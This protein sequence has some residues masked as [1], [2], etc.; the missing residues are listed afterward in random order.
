[1]LR[2][3][4]VAVYALALLVRLENLRGV[5]TQAGVFPIA[6][7]SYHHLRFICAG[8]ASLP[9]IPPSD[10]W[11]AFPEGG[12]VS[13]PFGADLVYALAAA[14]FGGA[15]DV[16]RC[17]EVAAWFTPIVSALTAVLVAA[18]AGRLRGPMAAFV[19]GGTAAL[20]PALTITGGVGYVD[21]HLF[22]S[23]TVAL[24]L[25]LWL[26]VSA[27][28]DNDRATVARAAAAGV[29]IAFGVLSTTV[30]ALLVPIAAVV[31][32][33]QLAGAWR[34]AAR[35]S[36]LAQRHATLQVAVVVTLAP[37]IATRVFADTPHAGA[38]AG[39]AAAVGAGALAGGLAL[40]WRARGARATLAV[41]VVAL[42]VTL[43]RFPFADALEFVR[44]GVLYLGRADPWLARI[45]EV[46][47][48]FSYGWQTA[49]WLLSGFLLVVPPAFL[50]WLGW[51][52][53]T[54]PA[55]DVALAALLAPAL[56][57]GLQ[58]RFTELLAVPLS[59][60]AGVLV[61]EL[62]AALAARPRLR[63]VPL[64]FAVVCVAPAATE[65]SFDEP[66]IVLDGDP[67]FV[68]LAPT[69]AWLEEATPPVSQAGDAPTDYAV[70]A[71][72]S[73][74]I[75]VV[76]FGERPVLGSPMGHSPHHRRALRDGALVFAGAPEQSLAVMA[77]RRVRYV[78]VTPLDLD[79]VC[80]DAHTDPAS[81][82]PPEGGIPHGVC[83][84]RSLY[85]RLV[86]EAGAPRGGED[87]A[88][89]RRI[90]LVYESAAGAPH[91]SLGVMSAAVRVFERV[92]GATLVGRAA[93]DAPV[94]V[95]ID[96]ITAQGRRRTVRDRVVADA[97]GGFA[98]RVP[99]ATGAQPGSAVTAGPVRLS[100]AG[101]TREVAVDEA[102]VLDGEVV[103]VGPME[104]P[105]AADEPR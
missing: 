24:F 14:L 3:S 60:A 55:A 53:R 4:Y 23:L 49:V 40:A 50:A 33:A 28:P 6:T 32:V 30:L 45:P 62:A 27:A 19:A 81:W 67:T 79:A 18:A 42:L 103:E 1:M 71:D 47:P 90:R 80:T 46:R 105:A 37:A 100:C 2:L 48:L 21:H 94:D 52:A 99:Y 86:R 59:V 35:R 84:E 63:F 31:G 61:H 7:D 54:A 13:W 5:F 97:S 104:A 68:R 20:L 74:G 29:V 76:A 56:V 43:P 92:R 36:L 89:L 9:R 41:L 10:P 70:A 65:L 85:A 51:R 16:A 98:V 87:A 57:L 25:W 39:F 73:L 38:L 96:L 72:W 83:R 26:P 77:E 15:H 69:L 44:F 82:T 8:A 75:W 64:A 91:G 22:E 17:W 102:A 78:L 11:L 88:A 34:D 58:I 93:P 101:A 66:Y 12:D 95:A